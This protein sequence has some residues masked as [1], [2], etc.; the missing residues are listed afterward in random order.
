M[1][2][3]VSA[4]GTELDAATSPVFGR[5]P[6]FVVVDTETMA[7]EGMANPALS[8]GGGA[9]TQAAQTVVQHGAEAVLSQNVGPNAFQVLEAGG[10]KVYR[11]G[12]GT[13]RQAVMDFLAGRLEPLQAAST[14]AHSGMR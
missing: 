10:V 14:S 2:V 13:V 6:A 9:G 12:A 1:K 8:L 11:V 4:E 3:A 7:Y 5:C